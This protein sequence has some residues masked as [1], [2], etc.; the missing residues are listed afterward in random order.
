LGNLT[1]D[2]SI[3]NITTGND[4]AVDDDVCAD[5]QVLGGS[6]DWCSW[7]IVDD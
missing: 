5:K 2:F 4:N 1:V 3:A 7:F 6:E